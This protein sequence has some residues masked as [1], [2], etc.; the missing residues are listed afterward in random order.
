MSAF[1][2]NEASFLTGPSRL[3]ARTY[4]EIPYRLS[5]V[6]ICGS[7]ALLAPAFL[8]FWRRKKFNAAVEEMSILALA[9]T[10]LAIVFNFRSV[11]YIMPIIPCLCLLL[12]LVVHNICAQRRFAPLIVAV[13]VALL[14]AESFVAAQLKIDHRRRNASD[15]QQI[16]EKLGELQKAGESTVLVRS[17]EGPVLYDSFYLFYANLRSAVDERSIEG[18][19]QNSPPSPAIGVCRAQDFPVVQEKYPGAVI[20]LRRGEFICWQATK[21]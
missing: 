19:R 21:A 2:F 15:Q 18:L 10:A 1:S 17:D 5:I 13:A 6:W 4:F 3:G 12:A 11:R 8:L 14:I 7:L 16:A 9:I 20:K